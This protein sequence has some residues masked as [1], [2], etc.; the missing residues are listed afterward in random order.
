MCCATEWI[1]NI[2][3]ESESEHR[4]IWQLTPLRP[5]SVH[6]GQT[7]CT[8]LCIYQG[9]WRVR[10][11]ENK[12]VYLT[13]MTVVHAMT[14][15]SA[16]WSDRLRRADQR[17]WVCLQRV[18]WQGKARSFDQCMYIWCAAQ[19]RNGVE[20]FTWFGGHS[21]LLRWDTQ[22]CWKSNNK[23]GSQR[24]KHSCA[25]RNSGRK[26]RLSIL[27]GKYLKQSSTVTLRSKYI[28]IHN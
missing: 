13:V 20:R 11:L 7:Q 21:W 22:R 5:Q 14:P 18:L 26:Q 25:L 28:C 15:S 10:G 27:Y 6:S 4:W 9:P 19:S 1:V 2:E 3:S 8:V 23:H 16:F 24:S 12:S 17:G